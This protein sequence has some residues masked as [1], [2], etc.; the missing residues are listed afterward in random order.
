VVR[1]VLRA[2]PVALAVVLLA[3]ACGGGGKQAQTTTGAAS[4]NPNV[5]AIKA[6]LTK[7]GYAIDDAFV[8]GTQKLHKA[9]GELDA[10]SVQ[11]DFTSPNSY[12]L[13]VT[14]FASPQDLRLYM[15]Q[16]AANL[17]KERKAAACQTDPQCK[18]F[19]KAMDG[20][21]PPIEQRP[22]GSVLYTG[23]VDKPSATL[24]VKDFDQLV[25]LAS[26]QSKAT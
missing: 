11:A 23:V 1:G 20:P 24:P 2:V 21:H 26:G 10:F 9:Q 13:G 15:R 7:A 17:A 12:H 19:F 14:V 22:L 18:S 6:R 16:Q 5:S 25:S 4:G 8:Q 3:S